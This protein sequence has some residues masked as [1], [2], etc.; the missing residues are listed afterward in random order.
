MSDQGSPSK[1]ASENDSMQKCGMHGPVESC[2]QKNN[3]AVNCNFPPSKSQSV[4]MLFTGTLF[5]C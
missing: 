3:F 4:G 2:T 1:S 5:D